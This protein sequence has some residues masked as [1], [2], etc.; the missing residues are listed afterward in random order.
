MEQLVWLCKAWMCSFMDNFSPL[1]LFYC[2]FP[3]QFQ[4]QDLGNVIQ[5]RQVRS[6]CEIMCGQSCYPSSWSSA[7]CVQTMARLSLDR[8]VSVQGQGLQ[9]QIFPLVFETP[10]IKVTALVCI[11]LK[12]N[13]IF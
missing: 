10:Q 4:L 13:I 1:S 2:V 8:D 11:L 7:G 9:L 6:E 3:A 12:G 5:H